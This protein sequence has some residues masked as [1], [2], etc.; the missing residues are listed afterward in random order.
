MMSDVSHETFQLAPKKGQR[1]ATNESNLE[2]SR[3]SFFNGVVWCGGDVVWHEW[4]D[5][6]PFVCLQRRSFDCVLFDF[7]M[8][9]RIVSAGPGV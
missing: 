3:I 2:G 5:D 6:E 9:W 4:L 8:P 7:V 1:R